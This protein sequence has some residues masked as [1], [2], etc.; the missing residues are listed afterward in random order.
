M[1]KN[2]TIAIPAN[3]FYKNSTMQGNFIR[4]L[5]SANT[6]LRVLLMYKDRNRNNSEFEIEKGLGFETHPFFGIHIQNTTGNDIVTKFIVSDEGAV[7]DTRTSGALSIGAA[8]DIIHIDPTITSSD[9]VN[10]VEVFAAN[11]FR[12]SA[13]FNVDSDCYIERIGGLVVSAGTTAL[14]ENQQRLKLIP[15]VGTLNVTGF[16]EVN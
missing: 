3:G 16:D 10:G 5:D 1:I 12:K 11:P 9:V 7:I 14:W 15:I 2:H 4:C 6:T 8:K 13:T